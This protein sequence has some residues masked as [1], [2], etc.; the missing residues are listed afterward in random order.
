MA[1]LPE[2]V[3]TVLRLGHPY[4]A[5]GHL[6]FAEMHPDDIILSHSGVHLTVGDI[7]DLQA[8]ILA[9]GH[10][11]PDRLTDLIAMTNPAGEA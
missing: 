4:P 10:T 1:L 7:R 2:T 8:H 5:I 6:A 9:M 11:S 3:R